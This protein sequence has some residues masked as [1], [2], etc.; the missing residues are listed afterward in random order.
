[1]SVSVILKK[2]PVSKCT[3]LRKGRKW[4]KRPAGLENGWRNC[5]RLQIPADTI[6]GEINT[7]VIFKNYIEQ[8]TEENL[9]S[10]YLNI[11]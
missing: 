5:R 2:G 3:A 9:V 1:M 7:A 4:G 11:P 8:Q 10:K 6:K